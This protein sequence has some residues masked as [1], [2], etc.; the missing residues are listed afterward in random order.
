MEEWQRL[1]SVGKSSAGRWGPRLWALGQ[2]EGCVKWKLWDRSLDTYSSQ[3]GER[4]AE[5]H[6]HSEM[7]FRWLFGQEKA[8]QP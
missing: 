6:A 8:R 3:P 5:C 1:T 2:L 7:A 4:Q